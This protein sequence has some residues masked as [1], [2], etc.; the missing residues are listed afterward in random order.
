MSEPR[1]SKNRVEVFDDNPGWEY[2]VF[3]DGVFLIGCDYALDAEVIK[4]RIITVLDKTVEMCCQAAT[5]RCANFAPPNPS[6]R[7]VDGI[8]KYMRPDK[9]QSNL[10]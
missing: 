1:A 8:N 10:Y 4:Q 5:L 2:Q 9:P 3:V 6:G 7:V